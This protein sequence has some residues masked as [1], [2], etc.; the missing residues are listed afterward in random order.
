MIVK[1]LIAQGARVHLTNANF[2]RQKI[3]KGKFSIQ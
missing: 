2:F 1:V 3:A